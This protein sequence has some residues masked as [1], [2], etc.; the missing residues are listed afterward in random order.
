MKARV[1][2]FYKPSVFDPQ[3]STVARSLQQMGFSSVKEVRMGK[4]IDLE[5]TDLSQA[6]AEAQIKQMCDKLLANP[7]IESYQ[8]ECQK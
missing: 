7:V 1:T 6:E 5:L 3:G 4:V 2:V 8:F